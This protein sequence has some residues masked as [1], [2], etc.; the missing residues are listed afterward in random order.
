MTK[1]NVIKE[2]K[3]EFIKGVEITLDLDKDQDKYYFDLA[4]DGDY[5]IHVES[6]KE[7]K[8]DVYNQLLKIAKTFDFSFYLEFYTYE[9]LEQF[10]K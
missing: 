5:L 8:Q 1:I 7:F 4:I 3:K 6:K 9:E 2:I 10:N